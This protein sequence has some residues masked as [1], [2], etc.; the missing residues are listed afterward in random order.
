ME[1]LAWRPLLESHPDDRSVEVPN[2]LRL[3]WVEVRMSFAAFS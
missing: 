1:V 3:V 2:A